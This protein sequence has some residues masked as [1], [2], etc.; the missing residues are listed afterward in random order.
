MVHESTNVVPE[1]A[2]SVKRILHVSFA[3]MLG[4]WAALLACGWAGGVVGDV[5][6]S[7]AAFGLVDGFVVQSALLA[8]LLGQAAT[9]FGVLVVGLICMA[10]TSADPTGVASVPGEAEAEVEAAPAQADPVANRPATEA[11]PAEAAA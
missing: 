6:R 5:A 4:C 1:P 3:V 7:A 11:V 8:A 9:W 2:V 10:R